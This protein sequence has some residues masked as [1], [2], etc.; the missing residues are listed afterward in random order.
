[1]ERYRLSEESIAYLRSKE[2]EALEEKYFEDG[3]EYIQDGKSIDTAAHLAGVDAD[4]LDE[5]AIIE[6]Y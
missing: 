3:I 2:Y 1:M 6:G 5:V 4:D